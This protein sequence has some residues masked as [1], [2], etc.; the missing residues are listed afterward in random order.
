MS[1]SG[2]SSSQLE[3]ILR[4]WIEQYL[5]GLQITSAGGDSPKIN[6]VAYLPEVSGFGDVIDAAIR[7]AII[8]HMEENTGSGPAVPKDEAGLSEGQA[9]SLGRGALSKLQSP[10]SIVMEGLQYLPQAT[11]IGFAVSLLPT[12]INELTRPG[13][14]FDLRFKRAVEE[15]YNA[16]EERKYI[17]DIGVGQKGLRF[18]LQ[19]GFMSHGQSGALSTNTQRLIRDG[20]IDRSLQGQIGY[21]DYAEGLF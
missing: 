15:E 21:I 16:I 7:D 2:Q 6:E 1:V 11:I 17:Y 18:Q 19:A 14:P 9:L 5:T 12:I 4:Q 20:G 10:Q 8:Q 13:G 3:S